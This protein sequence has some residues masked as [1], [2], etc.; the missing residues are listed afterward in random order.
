MV[1]FD[2]VDWIRMKRPFF[3]QWKKIKGWRMLFV[4]VFKYFAQIHGS[5]CS[6]QRIGTYRSMELRAIYC[7]C[8][9]LRTQIVQTFSR[10]VISRAMKLGHIQ[11]VLLPNSVTKK[12]ISQ[13]SNATRAV[14]PGTFS[15]HRTWGKYWVLSALSNSV[16]EWKLWWL[17]ITAS[18]QQLLSNSIYL[19]YFYLVLKTGSIHFVISLHS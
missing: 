4:F 12:N 11:S 13:G 6:L 17:L 10:T 19:Q 5:A 3:K 9:C 16:D 15:L 14:W 7:L 1:C 2:G 8:A 18:L